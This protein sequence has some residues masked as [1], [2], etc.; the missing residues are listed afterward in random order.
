MKK[1]ILLIFLI[2]AFLSCGQEN[3]GADRE[4]IQPIVVAESNGSVSSN[5][6]SVAHFEVAGDLTVE[7]RSL[8]TPTP[9]DKLQESVQ[10]KLMNDG[11][12]IN[13]QN[14]DGTIYVVEAAS[15][16]RSTNEQGFITSRNIAYSRAIL[17]AK[18]KILQLLGETVR[19]EKDLS[20][21]YNDGSGGPDPDLIEKASYIDKVKA[22]ASKSL[23]RALE[24]LGADK[25]EIM[26]MNKE[27]KEKMYSNEYRLL[28][29]TY[30]AA[31]M[32]GV[33][34]VKIVEGDNGNDYQVAVC[35]KFSPEQSREAAN[36]N[37]LG[38]SKEVFN[39]DAVKKLQSIDTDKLISNLGAQLFKDD[40]GKRFLVGF[41]QAS[42]R[43]ADRNQSRYEMA[44]YRKARLRA[45]SSIKDFLSE[46][47]VYQE[48]SEEA[49]KSISYFDGTTD[50]FWMDKMNLLIQAKSTTIKMS[51]IPIRQWKGIHPVSKNLVVGNIIIL[52]E[53]NTIE[54]EKPNSNAKSSKSSKKSSG[55]TGKSDFLES[56]DLE[57]EDF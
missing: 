33:T 6:K 45:I 53:N 30:G 23:D 3:K 17:K 26:Q 39:S 11:K 18:T 7:D 54:F 16:N 5:V 57:G 2:F 49:E 29:E 34:T 24:E 12:M 46:D 52:T 22:V 47:L 31:L 14:D 55:S 41:G 35:I 8:I 15:T 1:N 27:Q 4:E 25:S 38:A 13:V 21:F 40:N 50:E 43:K 44:G 20:D 56:S 32:N 36:Q 19:S 51:T 42:V 28:I 37:N 10:A 48:I 9:F